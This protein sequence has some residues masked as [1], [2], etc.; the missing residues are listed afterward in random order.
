MKYITIRESNNATDLAR[1]KDLL[2]ANGIDCR[3]ESEK[4]DQVINVVPNPF[5]ELQVAEQD[6][7]RAEQILRENA[8]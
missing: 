3:L 2:E 1:L 4:P 6:V 5:E 7:E 8:D